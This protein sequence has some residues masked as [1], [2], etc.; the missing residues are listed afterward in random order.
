MDGTAAGELGQHLPRS[1][2]GE[3][4]GLREGGGGRP[5]Y[6]PP[7]S[8]ANYTSVHQRI[9]THNSWFHK[10]DLRRGE[11]RAP[12]DLPAQRVREGEGSQGSQGT[13][14]L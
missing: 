2:S 3:A 13:P 7:V 10:Q 8:H 4:E 9:A 11:T 6:P 14:T 1:V 5:H 12:P